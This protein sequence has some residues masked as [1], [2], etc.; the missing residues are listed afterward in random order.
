MLQ[1]CV[2]VYIGLCIYSYTISRS[3]CIMMG[4][5]VENMGVCINLLCRLGICIYKSVCLF[6]AFCANIYIYI[7]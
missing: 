4:R 5:C 7:F 6:Y 1:I 3:V 2:H